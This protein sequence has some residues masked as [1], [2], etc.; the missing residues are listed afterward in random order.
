[1]AAK[2]IVDGIEDEYRDS[3]E[4]VRVNVLRSENQSILARYELQAT[5]T[6]IL[7]D[8]NGE[9]HWR[10]VGSLAPRQLRRALETLP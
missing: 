4:V 8:G 9:A 2:P 5:P 7:L 3:L 6:F 1:M 10:S